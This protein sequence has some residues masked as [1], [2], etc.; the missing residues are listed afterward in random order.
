[1]L[2]M[3]LEPKGYGEWAELGFRGDDTGTHWVSARSLVAV[4]STI[5]EHRFGEASP[6]STDGLELH[7]LLATKDAVMEYGFGMVHHWY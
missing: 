7:E 2:L 6:L 5:E 3:R 1:M 4:Q